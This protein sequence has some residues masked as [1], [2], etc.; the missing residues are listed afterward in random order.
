M[1][2][3]TG[4]LSPPGEWD[5]EKQCYLVPF[6][7]TCLVLGI[8]ST[9]AHLIRWVVDNKS[10]SRHALRKQH[11]LNHVEK[12]DML[13]RT[14]SSIGRF[15]LRSQT[16]RNPSII[17][18]FVALSNE[19]DKKELDLQEFGELIQE[20]VM[21]KHERFQ[22]RICSKDD[23]YFEV[24]SSRVSDAARSASRQHSSHTILFYS[25]R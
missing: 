21:K 8:A 4:M 24:R 17:S 15:A 1:M 9:R 20:R 16:R 11:S 3:I 13:H 7:L 23:R 14:L 18:F 22:C 5:Q 25:H 6:F 2:S 12:D 10:H 19:R